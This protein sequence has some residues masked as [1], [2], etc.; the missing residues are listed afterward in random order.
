MTTNFNFAQKKKRKK[1]TQVQ[2]KKNLPATPKRK[3]GVER[4]QSK[5][6]EIGK[7]PDE[8]CDQ[9]DNQI[10][11]NQRNWY[12]ERKGGLGLPSETET[13]RMKEIKEK[14]KTQ[15]RGNCVDERGIFRDS[16]IIS[17]EF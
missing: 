5:K 3:G 2:E 4:R 1:K 14:G 7:N 11:G 6:V 13:R 10:G 12:G 15:E 8:N 17:E 16:L 9:K